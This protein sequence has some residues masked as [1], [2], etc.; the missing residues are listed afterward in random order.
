M[1]KKPL[2]YKKMLSVGVDAKTVKGEKKGYLTGILY[3][4]PAETSGVNVCPFSTEGCR[5]ACLFTAGRGRFNAVQEAR[6]NKTKFMLENPTAFYDSVVYD[7]QALVEK[8]RKLDMKPCVRLNGTSDLPKLAKWFAPLFP[9]VQ[10][11]DYTKIPQP[12]TRIMPNYHLTFSRSEHNTDHCLAALNR[13]ISVAVVYN[14][15]R[16]QPL[17]K[18]GLFGVKVVDGDLSDLRFK[19]PKGVIVGLRA[20]GKA[21]QDTSGFV[22]LT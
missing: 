19:D 18:K 15:K 11:Y 22:Q 21:K 9:K 10:F 14:T 6:I 5:K 12:W 1:V 2:N 16:G 4:A 3:L 13:G 8:S 20:K 17:P 7:I